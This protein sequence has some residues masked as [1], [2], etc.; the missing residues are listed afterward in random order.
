MTAVILILYVGCIIVFV[1]LETS[2]L[3]DKKLFIPCKFH[4]GDS[5]SEAC[6]YTKVAHIKASSFLEMDASPALLLHEAK[7]A[8]SYFVFC[9]AAQ[10]WGDPNYKRFGLTWRRYGKETELLRS[11]PLESQKRPFKE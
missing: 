9:R 11:R 2:F 7:Q 5:F 8:C 1:K 10:L 3:I 6:L 4:T